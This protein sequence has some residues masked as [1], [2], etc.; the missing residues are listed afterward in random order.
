METGMVV[1]LI[2]LG[3]LN[4]ALGTASIVLSIRAQRS[5]TALVSALRNARRGR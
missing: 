4:L 1:A 2:V 5:W 3:A